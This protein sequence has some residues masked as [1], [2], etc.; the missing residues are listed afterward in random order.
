MRHSDG[1]SSQHPRQA[2]RFRQTRHSG[3]HPAPAEFRPLPPWSPSS[4]DQ[5]TLYQVAKLHRCTIGM[6]PRLKFPTFSPCVETQLVS[7]RAFFVRVSDICD[8]VRSNIV[9]QEASPDSRS[10]SA[11]AVDALQEA[12]EMPP[13]V[14]RSAALKK[15]GLLRCVADSHALIFRKKGRPRK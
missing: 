7:R 10:Q 2:G 1:Q 5:T 8:D 4:F 14:K 3:R 9:K 6:A 12:R 13:G 15:A 11:I